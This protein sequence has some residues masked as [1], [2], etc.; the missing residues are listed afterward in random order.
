[1]NLGSALTIDRNSKFRGQGVIV[2]IGMPAGKKI[3]FDESVLES[4]NPWVVRRSVRGGRYWGHRWQSDWDYDDFFGLQAGVDYTMGQDGVLFDPLKPA[5]KNDGEYRYDDN[6]EERQNRKK[7]LQEELKT[8][9]QQEKRD[10]L[11]KKDS[12]KQQSVSK[13]RDVA[14][15]DR[16]SYSP[17]TT[18]LN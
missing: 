8:I 10:S 14:Y 2:E 15:A 7:E 17:F 5:K 4:Y 3:N 16:I 13:A 9:E 6:N 18:L 11:Q 12:S 1:M